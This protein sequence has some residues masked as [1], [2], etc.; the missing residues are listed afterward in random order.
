MGIVSACEKNDNT[1]GLIVPDSTRAGYCMMVTNDVHNTL[2]DF[3]E[4]GL[5]P[6]FGAMHP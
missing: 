2:G 4:L 1:P 6:Y 3:Q 5:K